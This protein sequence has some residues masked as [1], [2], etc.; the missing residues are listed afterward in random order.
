MNKTDKCRSWFCV[1]NNPQKE[2][3]DSEPKEIAEA[4]LSRWIDEEHP[5]RSGAVAYCISAE[6]LE[7]QVDR[8]H[9][10]LC[11]KELAQ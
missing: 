6:G 1:L 7:H 2:Y 5:T 4:Y 10:V 9:V 11:A 8:S 3:P